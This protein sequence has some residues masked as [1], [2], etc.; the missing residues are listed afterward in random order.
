[1][2]LMGLKKRIVKDMS[3]NV[4]PEITFRDG[5]W[6]YR[7]VNGI[8]PNQEMCLPQ[9]PILDHI[10][11]AASMII[12]TH[13]DCGGGNFDRMV[14]YYNQ[15]KNIFA[16]ASQLCQD[17]AREYQELIDLDNLYNPSDNEPWWNK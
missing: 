3:N 12:R 4:F 5:R 6:F 8:D 11:E 7:I 2:D 13:D 10:W 15:A 14:S 17:K 16:G 9:D 1:M